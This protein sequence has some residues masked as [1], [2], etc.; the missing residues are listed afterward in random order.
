MT[1]YLVDNSV[2]QRF[3]R[4]PAVHAAVMDL[5]GRGDLAACSDLSIIEAGYSAKSADD[6]RQ[7]VEAWSSILLR[8]GLSDEVGP[9]AFDLQAAMFRAGRGR[10][11]GT[12]DLLQAAT[13]IVHGAVVIHYD[14]DFELLADVDDRLRQQWIVPRG[15]VD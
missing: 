15:S 5:M 6:H 14:A 8:L 2:L 10:S 12:F 3:P 11:A 13:A 9:V 1:L 7:I 4:S